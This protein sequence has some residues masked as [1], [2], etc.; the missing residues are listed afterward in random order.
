MLNSSNGLCTSA[1]SSLKYW[2]MFGTVKSPVSMFRLDSTSPMASLG[3]VFC[4]GTSTFSGVDT[5]LV[6]GMFETTETRGSLELVA[7]AG[8]GMDLGAPL[9]EETFLALGTAADLERFMALEAF[10]GMLERFMA[11]EAFTGM[12]V[13]GAA[14]LFRGL[15]WPAEVLTGFGVTGKTEAFTDLF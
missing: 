4:C 10:T 1:L 11:L 5:F 13:T 7:G 12:G 9:A 2:N 8:L 3:L 15:T 14:D 6:P